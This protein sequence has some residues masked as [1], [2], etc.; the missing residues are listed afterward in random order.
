MLHVENNFNK[1]GVPH[2]YIALFF[3]YVS[4]GGLGE[5][6]CHTVKFVKTALNRFQEH[7]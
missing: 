3:F 1:N 6:N 4:G 5:A 7:L 2:V